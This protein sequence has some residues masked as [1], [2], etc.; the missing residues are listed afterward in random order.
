[1]N[2]VI[3]IDKTGA[4]QGIENS[5]DELCLLTLIVPETLS[6]QSLSRSL[7]PASPNVSPSTMAISYRPFLSSK[8]RTTELEAVNKGLIS[9]CFD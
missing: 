3:I 4:K 5:T 6:C 7:S 9:E 1:M 8:K 2:V